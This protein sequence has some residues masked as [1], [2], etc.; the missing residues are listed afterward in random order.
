[1]KIE[2]VELRIKSLKDEIDNLYLRIHQL[3]TEIRHIAPPNN[4]NI[5]E[6]GNFEFTDLSSEIK[7]LI[8]K[9]S[10]SIGKYT[11][12]VAKR[13]LRYENEEPVRI[14]TKEALVLILLAA[15]PNVHLPKTSIL[16]AIWREDNYKNSRSMDVYICKVRKLLNKD[17]SI[18]IYNTHG[19]GYK[20]IVA[21]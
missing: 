2:N 3:K 21:Q 6:N 7:N 20:L 16:E 8:R 19:K 17:N 15:Y 12:E 18:A 1:M 11:L 10:F 14:T 5:F 9:E 13:L 4:R